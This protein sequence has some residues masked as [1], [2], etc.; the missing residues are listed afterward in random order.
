MPFSDRTDAGRQLAAQLRRYETEAP[1]VL[2]LPRGGVAVAYEVALALK[3]PLDVWIVRK[4][5]APGYPELGLGA[6]AEGGVVFLDRRTI[7]GVR[8]SDEQVEEI[9]RRKEAEV[10][11]RIELF[12][13]E[14]SAPGVAGRVVILVDDGIATGGTARAAVQALRAARARKIVLAVPVAS[15]DVLEEFERLVDA[16]VCVEPTPFL[17]AIGAWYDDFR[18]VSDEEGVDLLERAR[19]ARGPAEASRRASMPDPRELAIPAGEA[20][21]SGTLSIPADA[22]G[23]VLFA[24]GSGSSRLSPRNRHVASVLQSY[25][26][27]TLLF[28]L[29]TSEE[30]AIDERTGELRFDIDFL[31]S[32]LVEVTDWIRGSEDGQHLPLG[33]FGSSTGAAAALVAASQRPDAIRAVVSRG[34][35]PDLAWESLPGV[36]AP[37]LLIVGGRDYEV[38]ELNKRAYARL[39]ST[40]EVVIVPGATHLF[41]EPGTLDAV[42]RLAG[43]W[44]E[45]HLGHAGRAVP[46]SG[47]DA[48]E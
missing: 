21:L 6:V 8:A 44:F 20:T 26:L 28:D 1:L 37:T 33:Y 24:H 32:R 14:R 31:A 39:T 36:R 48:R 10:R 17:Y 2:G 34:G 42:A 29:L 15:T 22:R 35:R 47:E 46:V 30:E 45:K 4:V 40:R 19:G 27:A 38:I 9:V 43:E 11:E 23:L 3:A 12:R 7:E 5:G 18:Q 25:G 41:E 16:V 13:G